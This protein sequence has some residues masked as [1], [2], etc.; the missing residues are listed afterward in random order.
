MSIVSFEYDSQYK[1]QG[2][3]TNLFILRLK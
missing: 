2:M 3:I 1:T